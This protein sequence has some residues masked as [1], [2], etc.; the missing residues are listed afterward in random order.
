MRSRLMG[1]AAM[2]ALC[3]LVL[4]PAAGPVPSALAAG[5]PTPATSTASGAATLGVDDSSWPRDISWPQC[6]APYPPQPAYGIVGVNAG[7]VFSPNHC[8]ASELAWAGGEGAGLY[9]NTGNPGPRLSSHWPEGQITPMS[10]DVSNPDTAACAYDYGYNAAADSY[11]TAEAAFRSLPSPASPADSAWWLDV[12][13]A[14]SWR[15]DASLNVANLEGAVYFLQ[16]VARVASIGFYSTQY[17]WDLITGGTNAFAAYPSW[18]AGSGNALEASV[19]CGGPGFTGGGV[20]LTQYQSGGYDVDLRCSAITQEPSAVDVSPS[21]EA[22]QVGGVHRFLATVV[23]QFGQPIYPQPPITWSVNGGGSI[24]AN[25]VFTAGPTAGGPFTVTAS[26]G[27]ASGTASVTVT[28]LPV[29]T[30]ISVSPASTSVQTGG[31][32][33]FTASAFDQYGRQLSP[34]PALTWSVSGGGSI[35][36]DGVFTASASAGGPFTVTASSGGVSGTADVTVA[37][38]G[39]IATATGSNN[40]DVIAMGMTAQPI[41]GAY[42]LDRANKAIAVSVKDAA[43]TSIESNVTFTYT[44]APATVFTLAAAGYDALSDE[45]NF[46][47]SCLAPGAASVTI[48]AHD[49]RSAATAT[50]A[51]LT[52]SCAT[53]LAPSTPG[54]F[55]VIPAAANVGP[56]DAT[57]F[58][59]EV[60]DA[61]GLAAPDGTP[62]TAVSDGVGNVVGYGGIVGSATTS[63]GTAAFTYLAP[64]NAGTGTVTVRV[65]NASPSAQELPFTIATPP[66]PVQAYAAASALGVTKTG[67]FTTATKVSRTGGYVTVAI[68]LGA[69][70]AGKDVTIEFATKSG[71]TWSAFKARTSRIADDSGV[72]Y[73]YWRSVSA[74]WISIRA[75]LD[76]VRSNAVQARWR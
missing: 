35:S 28:A 75:S 76:G 58:T 17:Q 4:G 2:A 38:V 68:S 66:A 37:S 64:G 60:L 56:G 22:V 30:S 16:S 46:S 71:G 9:A 63:N 44:Y 61:Q 54:S 12:E 24:A 7:I 5:N 15:S 49:G 40:D 72:V 29:L 41:G 39:D 18:L 50:T 1:A 14:N 74:D 32:Q 33:V 48:T 26:S 10:C 8:L 23:D 62:V 45:W 67:P 55:T 53:P 69:V 34:Q 59:V 19:N 11:A 3:T 31:T 57:A 47:A 42:A 6:G 70:A 13:T 43:G 51:A 73:F 27:A 21:S 36:P 52:L 20:A 25:G 65:T